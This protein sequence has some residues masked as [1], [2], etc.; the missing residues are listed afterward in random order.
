MKKIVVASK[1]PVKIAAALGGFKR[2]FPDE[3]F[4]AEGVGAESGVND[5]PISNDETY[6]GAFNRANN[7]K[8]MQPHADY[9][10]GLE[11]GIED[12]GDDMFAFAWMVILGSDG[13]IG[14]GK[15]GIFF[16][17][18]EVA[19]LIRG[20]MELG[21]AD[22]IVFSRNNSKQAGGAIGLLTD[23][24]IDRE[25]YYTEAIIFALVAFKHPE[26]YPL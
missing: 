22:D 19:T 13:R 12:T 15:T 4:E 25:A 24:V 18:G 1:N 16:L 26:F 10:I 3:E 21:E 2:M 17:P 6:Q 11:G 23:D 8:T 5:Q 20:G 7:A 14:K 9:W